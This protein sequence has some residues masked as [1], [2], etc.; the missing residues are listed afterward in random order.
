MTDKKC[1]DLNVPPNLRVKTLTNAIAACGRVGKWKKALGLLRDV[2]N[3]VLVSRNVK[4]SSRA[5]DSS[6]EVLLQSLRLA[7]NF[8]IKAC[9]HSGRWQ[10][11]LQILKSMEDGELQI[12]PNTESYKGCIFGIFN[13]MRNSDVKNRASGYN[14]DFNFRATKQIEKLTTGS[15]FQSIVSDKHQQRGSTREKWMLALELFE[16]MGSSN[17]DHHTYLNLFACL[18]RDSSLESCTKLLNLFYKFVSN[19]EFVPDERAYRLALRACAKVGDSGKNTE[20]NKA[21]KS[22][23]THAMQVLKIMESKQLVQTEVESRVESLA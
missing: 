7:C 12:K 10:E 3:I 4:K 5:D 18:E 1:I 17:R 6:N 14:D 11:A 21:C 16:Q 9:A 8:A 23:G 13:G 22:A 15:E 19:G 2:R 20:K